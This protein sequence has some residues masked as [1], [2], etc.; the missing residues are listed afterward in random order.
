MIQSEVFRNL[1]ITTTDNANLR[2][3]AK[4]ESRKISIAQQI[5]Y[6]L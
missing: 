1:T 6:Y 5:L 2:P 4:A 3:G